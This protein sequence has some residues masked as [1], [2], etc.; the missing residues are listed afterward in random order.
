MREQNV[1]SVEM[2][3]P[4]ESKRRRITVEMEDSLSTSWRLL[5]GILG[6]LDL[7]LMVAALALGVL[8]TNQSSYEGSERPPSHTNT[9]SQR[10]CYSGSCPENWIWNRGNCYYLSRED[11]N[12]SESQTSCRSMNSSLLKI[13]GNKEVDDFLKLLT[14]HYWIGL[15]R[16]LSDGPWL[17]EDR[18]ELSHDLLSVKSHFMRGTCVQYGLKNKFSSENC[19]YLTHYI[20]EQRAI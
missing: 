13:D 1:T 14:F 4:K 15:S 17:W 11:K 18:S 6:I 5:T 9:T 20:C 16:N 19:D 3:P 12:W 10:A 8:I 2:K 7:G